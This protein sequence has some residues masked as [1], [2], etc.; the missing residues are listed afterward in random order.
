MNLLPRTRTRKHSVPRYRL[1]W[2][3]TLLIS[4]AGIP[5][6]SLSAEA[7]TPRIDPAGIQG[8]LVI[9]GGGSLPDQVM[10]RFM[11]LAGGEKAHLVIIPT[12]S[13]RADEEET[14]SLLASWQDRKSAS[15]TLLHT[16]SRDQANDPR[17]L[18]P[19]ARA[20]GIWFTGGIQSRVTEAYLGTLLEKELA[21]LLKRGGVIGGSSAG[22]AIQSRVMIAGGSDEANLQTGFD[23][24]PGTIIDQHFLARKRQVR[25]IGAVTKHPLRVGLGIDEGTALVVRGRRMEVV[26]RSSVTVC[27]AASPT[28]DAIQTQVRAGQPLDLTALRRATRDR[29]QPAFPPEKMRPSRL[30]SGS[31]LIVGGG[32]FPAPMRKK[33]IELA[34]GPDALIIVLPT[35]R[36]E[37]LPE[38]VGQKLF[39]D[40]GARNVKVLR[41][42]KLADVESKA[43][44]HLLEKAGGIWFG[45]GRQWRFVDAYEETAAL[46]WIHAV[47]QR[48]GVIGGSS[49]GASI[50]AEYLVRGNPLGNRDMM[51]A[52]YE[53]GFGFLPGA[54]VDQHFAQ[55]KRFADMTTVMK[56]HPQ[57]LGIG[58]DESTALLVQGSTGTVMGGGKVHI[59]NWRQ[60]PEPGKPDYQSFPARSRYD[61]EK[62]KVLFLPP[63]PEPADKP[64]T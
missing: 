3:L 62:R 25:L 31:L 4:L 59:Y 54:A 64:E 41:A 10:D 45:G 47:L 21:H 20:T 1:A 13:R 26:G 14:K 43:T 2:R 18:K 51:A 46:P 53:R 9:A 50:Q 61:L 42:R 32:G 17:F 11:K 12:A 55:R 19:V 35:A 7:A 39:E 58:I 48:G 23:L 49:A 52:G 36:E 24:L 60:A 57:L 33:F 34:G 5:R 29:Q 30:K 40:A 37:P 16:R 8:S 22:A 44:R 63:P 28:Q 15:L 6:V 38:Q 27:L 56:R